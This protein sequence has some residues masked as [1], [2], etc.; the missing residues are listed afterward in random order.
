M[1]EA[2]AHAPSVS[3]FAPSHLPLTAPAALGEDLGPTK[4]VMLGTA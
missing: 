4:L 1:T 2:E 3:G